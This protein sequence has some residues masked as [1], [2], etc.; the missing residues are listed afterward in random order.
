MCSQRES[1]TGK[2]PNDLLL[3]SLWF[4]VLNSCTILWPI[5]WPSV[6]HESQQPLYCH[7]SKVKLQ[8]SGRETLFKP[9][10]MPM[11]LCTSWL[12]MQKKRLTESVTITQARLF[13]IIAGF[14]RFLTKNATT[15]SMTAKKMPICSRLSPL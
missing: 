2:V 10:N 1:G 9:L 14:L 3:Q 11:V 5:L 12:D 15:P 8:G 13:S 6:I 4:D 7:M